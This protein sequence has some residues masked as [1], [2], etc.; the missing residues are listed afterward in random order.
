MDKLGSVEEMPLQR[1]GDG[2][3]FTLLFIGMELP[4]INYDEY[5]GK[6]YK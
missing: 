3:D 5:S 1:G 2:K 6:P 4:R